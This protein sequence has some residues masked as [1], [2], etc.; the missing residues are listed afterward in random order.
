[1]VSSLLCVFSHKLRLGVP[2]GNLVQESSTTSDWPQYIHRNL[3]SLL[4]GRPQYT[5]RNLVSH[6]TGRPQYTPRNLASLLTG[7]PQYTHWPTQ[8]SPQAQR[9]VCRMFC[10]WNLLHREYAFHVSTS[11][12]ACLSLT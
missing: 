12:A 7:Q 3:V 11:T 8:I 1:M 4:T 9:K 2:L 5:P 6:L 10:L